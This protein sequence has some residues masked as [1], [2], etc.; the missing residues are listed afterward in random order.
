VARARLGA[1]YYPRAALA[2]EED[3]AG[4][5]Q[6]GV[7]LDKTLLTYFEVESHCRFERH[8]HES[9][10]I[11]IVLDG[12][13]FFELDAETFCVRQGEVIATPSNLPHAVFTK[14]RSA[15]AVDAW[16]PVMPQY[17][18]LPTV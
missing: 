17:A 14:D 10:Q 12:E 16:S 11:T 6:W 8:H 3:V 18:G 2:L 13:L 15:I 9:E 4:A 1:S 7:A 5:R